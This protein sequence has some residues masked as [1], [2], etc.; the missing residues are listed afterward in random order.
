M[1]VKH[2]FLAAASIWIWLAATAFPAYSQGCSDAGACSIAGHF[3]NRNKTTA[4]SLESSL[5]LGEKFVLIQQTLIQY[6]FLLKNDWNLTF[7]IPFTVVAG[8]LGTTAG[9]GDGILSAGKTVQLHSHDRLS[10]LVAARLKSNDAGKSINGVPLPMAYQ[11][12]LGTYDL[13]GGVQFLRKNWEI[14]AAYQHPFGRNANRYTNDPEI[15][16]KRYIYYESAYLKRG[17]DLVFRYRL[18]LPLQKNEN[19]HISLAAVTIYRL[20]GDSILKNGE[21]VFLTGSGGVT[22]NLNASYVTRAANGSQTEWLIAFPVID[23]KYRADGLTRN[24]V[25]TFRFSPGK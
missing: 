23:R 20:F 10:F 6:R 24:F 2:R 1:N 21:E 8:N 18:R 15:T 22:L 9:I 12:S 5:G 14:Y 17:D 4:W 3:E 25:V 19:G 11:T 16:D 13:I 7:R